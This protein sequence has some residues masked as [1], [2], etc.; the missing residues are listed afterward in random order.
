MRHAE[1]FKSA[2]KTKRQWLP[3]NTQESEITVPIKFTKQ[4]I[5]GSGQQYHMTCIG[6][7]ER[8]TGPFGFGN[9]NLLSIDK[10][11]IVNSSRYSK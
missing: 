8:S 10:S 1:K 9:C 6:Q 3:K 7:V 2:R 4:I 11:R 5:L